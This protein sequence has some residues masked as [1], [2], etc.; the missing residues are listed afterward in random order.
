MN[1]YRGNTGLKKKRSWLLYSPAVGKSRRI[2]HFFFEIARL[3]VIHQNTEEGMAKIGKLPGD[4]QRKAHASKFK[5]YRAVEENFRHRGLCES[6]EMRLQ[7]KAT[8]PKP[9]GLICLGCL[10]TEQEISLQ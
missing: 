3:Q 10:Q 1:P 7:G 2:R 6:C 5:P 4:G 9:Q 8:R